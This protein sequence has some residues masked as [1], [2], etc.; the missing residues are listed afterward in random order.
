MPAE[1]V[2]NYENLRKRVKRFLTSTV[3]SRGEVAE[4]LESIKPLGDVA[5]FGGMLR[6]I[7]LAGSRAFNSDV[8]IVIRTDDSK[9]LEAI[10]SSYSSTINSF[11]GYRLPLKE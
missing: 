3:N 10:L 1:P 6:D 9:A 5:I 11:G 2:K 4:F 7:S 8:D